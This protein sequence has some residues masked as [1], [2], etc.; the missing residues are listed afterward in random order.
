M[1]QNIAD[2]I[3]EAKDY[4]SALDGEIGDAD[5]GVTMSIGFQAV[6]AE[7]SKRNVDAMAPEDLMNLVAMAFLDSI[8]A[9]TGPLYATGFRRAAQAVAGAA[10][11]TSE[12]Q[13]A[14]IKGITDGVRE[15]GKGR[16]GDKTMLDAWI[17]ATDAAANAVRRSATVEEMWRDVLTAAEAGAALTCSMIAARGRAA[18]LGERALGHL[19]PG[20]AS[21][22]VILKAMALT[23]CQDGAK[24][25]K[26]VGDQ[27][28]KAGKF[29]GR[30]IK[31]DGDRDWVDDP[32]KDSSAQAGGR[33]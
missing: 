1:F 26:I 8:G 18:R 21:A 11:A 32:P 13:A 25:T 22:V 33:L 16:R 5:H 14:L 3:E 30:R 9:S 28:P 4:L 17:P 19:D 10:G 15:R 27:S 12:V 7:L 2:S 23:F 31:I 20:A 6:K 24:Q 29:P